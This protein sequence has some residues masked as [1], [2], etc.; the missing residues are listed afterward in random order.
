MVTFKD[1]ARRGMARAIEPQILF[2]L[3]A[4]VLLGTIWG[5]TF[6]LIKVKTAA[7]EHAA[8]A[9]SRELLSTYEAQV[10]RALRE[11][12]LTLLLVKDWPERSRRPAHP[13]RPEEHGSAASG[14][15]V[16]GQRIRSRRPHRG[17]Y[18]FS[19]RPTRDRSG[20]AANLA[21]QQ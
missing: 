15:A 12:D 3:I 1:A 6:G 14:L 20:H 7:A 17:K 5:T 10:V 16:R 2:S 4:L 8:A 13:R 11:I 21:Q 9:T 19:H 18:P